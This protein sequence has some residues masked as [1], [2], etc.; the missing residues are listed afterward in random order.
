[1]A[2]AAAGQWQNCA[3]MSSSYLGNGGESERGRAVVRVSCRAGTVAGGLLL[4][5]AAPRDSPLQ[6]P[7]SSFHLL[8]EP[9]Q[10]GMDT[11]VVRTG[12]CVQAW[13]GAGVS[14]VAVAG[15]VLRLQHGETQTCLILLP[16]LPGDDH[17]VAMVV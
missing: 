10:A 5:F 8:P 6:P 11:G 9:L 7:L 16:A 15:V 12:S 4:A 13:A 3:I 2:A 1:M 17:D 14:H